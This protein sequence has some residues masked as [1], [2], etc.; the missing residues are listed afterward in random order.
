MFFICRILLLTLVGI[1]PAKASTDTAQTNQQRLQIKIDELLKQRHGL[2]DNTD[3]VQFATILTSADKLADIC[4]KPVL[5]IAGND[6]RL[7]GKRSVIA[8]CGKRKRFVQIEVNAKGTWWV[9]KHE[10]PA[11]QVIEASDIEPH[12]GTLEHQPAIPIFNAS[13]IIGQTTTRTIQA[14]D[15]VLDNQLRQQWRV[16]AGQIVDILATGSGFRIRSQGKA[17]N[18]AAVNGTLRVQTRNR[19]TVTGQVNTRGEVE[20]NL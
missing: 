13:Q 12:T 14:G 5:S 18:N 19:Q 2:G 1:M 9:A 16:R 20:I 3:L 4:E 17:L 8:T 6:K 10:L 7:T 15:A 11:G